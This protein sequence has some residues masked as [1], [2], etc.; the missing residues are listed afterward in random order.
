MEYGMKLAHSLTSDNGVRRARHAATLLPAGAAL[1][2]DDR[3]PGWT[4]GN[5]V[6]RAIRGR[7]WRAVRATRDRCRRESVLGVAG[8]AADVRAE[9]SSDGERP[10]GVLRLGEVVAVVRDDERIAQM[11]GEDASASGPRA[12]SAST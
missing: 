5:H 10:A 9:S 6:D 1:K 7:L 2:D 12:S 3:R 8:G 4:L 11:G